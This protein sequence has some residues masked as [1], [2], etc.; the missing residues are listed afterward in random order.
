MYY[1]DQDFLCDLLMLGM[2]EVG[3][4]DE[5]DNESDDEGNE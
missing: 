4:N 2:G 5:E 1:E 3:V